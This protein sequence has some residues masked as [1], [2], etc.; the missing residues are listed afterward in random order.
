MWKFLR[1]WWGDDQDANTGDRGEREAA[2]YLK[3][4]GLVVLARNWRNPKD[5]RE[6]IDLV[7]REGELVVFVEVK[8][9]SVR[10]RVPGYYAVNGK[11]K[12]ILLRAC[13]AYLGRLRP[14]ADYYR[15]DVVEVAVSPGEASVVRHF[16]NVPLFP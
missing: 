16:E 13:R 5:R 3:G 6:E 14:K 12:A 15:F 8:T 10:A 7:C 4:K 9:R 1:K 11:K 2:D